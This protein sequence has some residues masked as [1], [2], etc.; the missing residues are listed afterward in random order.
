MLERLKFVHFFAIR[1]KSLGPCWLNW[2]KWGQTSKIANISQII[3]E[4]EAFEV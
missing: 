1:E 3:R 4:Y 2:A